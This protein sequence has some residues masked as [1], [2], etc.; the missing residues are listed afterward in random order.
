MSIC[1]PLDLSRYPDCSALSERGRCNRLTLSICQGKKCNFR[2]TEK[3]DIDSF[4]YAYQRL[5]SLDISMQIQIAEKYYGGSMPWN[6]AKTVKKY[7]AKSL[8][9]SS[10]KVSD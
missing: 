9:Y 2:R 3:E 6:E 5:L 4:Q 8:T 10:N 1:S 7:R